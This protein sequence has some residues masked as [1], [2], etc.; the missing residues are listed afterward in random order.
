MN[1]LEV[2]DMRTYLLRI[3]RTPHMVQI[4]Y[5]A[6]KSKTNHLSGNL[7]PC[8]SHALFHRTAHN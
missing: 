7:L 3:P 1:I 4:Y 6:L 2:G 8:A 5:L